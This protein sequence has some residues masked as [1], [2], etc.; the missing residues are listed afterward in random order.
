MVGMQ[1]ARDEAERHRLIRGA[2]DLTRAEHPGG[3]AIEQQA[4]QHFRGVGLSTAC[5]IPGIQ[6]RQVKLGHAVYHEAR[7]MVG[8]QTV[9]QAHRQVERLIIV[10][11]FEGS[12]HAYQYTMTDERYLLL[13]DKL[14]EG[15]FAALDKN[16]YCFATNKQLP[17]QHMAL[18]RAR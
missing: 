17:G 12:T 10:H 18:P 11:C 15:T 16:K 1:V 5:P 4:Q 14:L 6:R 9:A 7:Q 8:G 13:S 3:I 2:L